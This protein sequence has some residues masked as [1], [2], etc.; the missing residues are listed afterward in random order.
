MSKPI[1]PLLGQ[2]PLFPDA[3][4]QFAALRT[5]ET[6]TGVDL[7]CDVAQSVVAMEDGVVAN[8]EPFTGAH[9]VDAPSPWWNNTWAVLVEGPSGVIA[10]GEIQ[11]CVAI[12]QCVVAGER[13]GT[14][15]PVLR[16]FKGRPMV[17]LH[18]E[19]LRS[20]TLA[21]TTWWNDTTRPDHLLDP[22][23]LLRRASGELFPR[24]FDLGHYDGRRFR[25]ALAP[26]NIRY[27]FGDKLQ[28]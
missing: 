28:R 14:I 11:P 26:T 18:L 20:G 24:T 22:T 10:Y 15:L 27:R 17:M 2:T 23:P 7:Y 16:T 3:P 13:V 6:H 21:T 1:W 8:V 25:D 9:V 5:H 4:G 19:L 12:G